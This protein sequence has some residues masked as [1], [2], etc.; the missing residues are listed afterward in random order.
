MSA[1]EEQDQ[2]QPEEERED[3]DFTYFVRVGTTDLDGTK[4]VETALLDMNGVGRRVSRIIAQEIDVSP[5]ET[6]GNLDD[7]K[8]EE[9]VDAIENFDEIGPAWMMNREFDRYTG[10]DRHVV[11]TELDITREEDINRMKKIE[12]YKGV[13]HEKGKKVRGQRTKSTGRSEGTVAVKVSE[14]QAE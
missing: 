8:I 1:D 14:L 10:E 9:V 4:S 12:S 6:L 2:E 3:E 13:R 7:D 11:G 5:R